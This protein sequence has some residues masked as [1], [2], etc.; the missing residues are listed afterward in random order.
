MIYARASL[1][2]CRIERLHAPDR[3]RHLAA[4]QP[5]KVTTLVDICKH[6]HWNHTNKINQLYLAVLLN[7][8]QDIFLFYS[9]LYT[10]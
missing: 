5:S 6:I 4:R 1:L 2:Y 7:N 8:L 9:I 3:R 10:I